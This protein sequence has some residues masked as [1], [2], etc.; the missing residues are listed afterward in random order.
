MM[1]IEQ[2]GAQYSRKL[3][4]KIHWK[5][6]IKIS[7]ILFYYS[8]LLYG[9]PIQSFSREKSKSIHVKSLKPIV[10]ESCVNASRMINRAMLVSTDFA[11]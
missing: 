5:I 1:N 11:L 10:V 6:Q 7:I 2:I 3:E 9:D 8:N 4:K